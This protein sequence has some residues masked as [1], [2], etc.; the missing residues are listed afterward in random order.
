MNIK[1]NKDPMALWPCLLLAALCLLPSTARAQDVQQTEATMMK[2]ADE[3]IERYRKGDAT[4]RFMTRDGR[5]VRGAAV[6]VRHKSHDFL[7]GC[8]VFDIVGHGDSP[9]EE[10]FKERFKKIFNLAVFPF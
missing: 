10:L 4:V 3:N 9:N 7:V 2:R 6:E 5:P 8:I 1:I